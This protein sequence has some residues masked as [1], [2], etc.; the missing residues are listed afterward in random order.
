MNKIIKR[1]LIFGVVSCCALLITAGIIVGIGFTSGAIE[2]NQISNFITGQVVLK[3]SEQI[4][5]Y[6]LSYSRSGG[7]L[8]IRF[9]DVG[10]CLK[11]NNTKGRSMQPYTK[12]GVILLIDTCF[13]VE[14][15]EVNDTIS[16]IIGKK[17]IHH[18][19][20]SIDF[21]NKT[22]LTK[23]DFNER[24]DERIPFDQVTGK[25]IGVFNVTHSEGGLVPALYIIDEN[26]VFGVVPRINDFVFDSNVTIDYNKNKKT[27]RELN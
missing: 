7:D 20:I 4:N 27:E 25:S 1:L 23:G 19:I 8:I 14:N 5:D 18:R 24:P 13:P 10:A 9:R 6:D 21:K 22:I 2:V 26:F 17:E 11:I 12:G 3:V 16:F 15:L